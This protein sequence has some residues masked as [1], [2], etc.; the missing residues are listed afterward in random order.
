MMLLSQSRAW[1]G[2]AFV[3][4][5]SLPM[6]K[7]MAIILKKHGFFGSVHSRHQLLAAAVLFTHS[8]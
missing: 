5:L 3:V 6:V 4:W 7:V 1:V 8:I 2:P